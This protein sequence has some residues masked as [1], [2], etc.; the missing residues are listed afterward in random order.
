MRVVDRKQLIGTTI[1]RIE[2][3]R[4]VA[5]LGPR[6]SG[7]TTLARQVV[8]QLAPE[9]RAGNYFDLEDDRVLARLSDPHLALAPLKGLV[10]IDEIQRRP[11][12]FPAL[13]V[14]ADR[15]G[16]PAKFLILG[17]ASRDLIRQGSET[18]A[19]RVSFLEIMPFGL[20]ELGKED[21]EQHWLRGGFPGSLLADDEDA[22]LRW[23]QDYI[24]SFLERDI[25]LLGFNLPPEA[26]RRFWMMLAHHHGQA[27][28]ALELSRSLGINDKTARR[29]LDILTG[30]FMIRQLQP[31]FENIGKR[32]VKTPKV[33]F[34]D[35]GLFHSL[36]R[37][38][39]REELLTHPKL[40]ASWEGYALEQTIRT[41]GAAA[42]DVFFWGWHGR[43][44]LD[45]LLLRGG[46]RF[47]FEFKYASAPRPGAV[48]DQIIEL[49][50]LR[51]LIIVN[52]GEQ[53]HALAE[54]V[55]VCGLD[56]LSLDT[57]NS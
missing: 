3:N 28:N 50:Q 44:E 7:K 14:L 41:F 21:R 57:L 48:Q 26:M 46:E 25:P 24:R 49:L 31:W 5:L 12:L 30:T 8:D 40:G 4:V 6:Q 53:H 36:L 2:T 9:A 22:S 1:R 16:T 29:Y 39:T 32:Q 19:G 45:L 38:G 35:S 42:E 37:T 13:R 20:P 56:L 52:P 11:D 55:H 10:V 33:Y 15:P 51:R 47:G 43:G 54:K 27:F 34:R 18:L 23:R 17:S